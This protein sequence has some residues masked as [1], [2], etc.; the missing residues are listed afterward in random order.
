M[1]DLPWLPLILAPLLLAGLVGT[2]A[3]RG[4]SGF[5]I[6]ALLLVTLYP[7]AHWYV[8][9]FLREAFFDLKFKDEAFAASLSSS[10]MMAE[11]VLCPLIFFATAVN[12]RRRV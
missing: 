6:A 10:L 4:R 2:F 9:R 3:R 1:S 12:W 7:V 8:L 5:R 11:L